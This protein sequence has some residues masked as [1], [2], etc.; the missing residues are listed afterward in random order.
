M[1]LLERGITCNDILVGDFR[2][3]KDIACTTGEEEFLLRLVF[4]LDGLVGGSP[5]GTGGI[6][7]AAVV[8][9]PYADADRILHQR[10][11]SGVAITSV[12]TALLVETGIDVK[13][14][15][16]CGP[17]SFYRGCQSA[18]APIIVEHIDI[19]NGSAGILLHEPGVAIGCQCAAAVGQTATVVDKCI[20]V[21]MEGPAF[22]FSNTVTL[23]KETLY[24]RLQRTLPCAFG[25]ETDAVDAVITEIFY[26]FLGILIFAATLRGELEKILSDIAFGIGYRS[27]PVDEEETAGTYTVLVGHIVETSGDT[28]PGIRPVAMDVDV[29]PHVEVVTVEVPTGQRSPLLG[30]FTD[31]S[32]PAEVLGILTCHEVLVGLL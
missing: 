11:P 32:P 22:F 26:K 9:T 21:H 29:L 5:F 13:G 10:L 24:L 23:G 27:P 25:V 14:V 20:P 2:T 18:F 1:P 6:E 30:E 12:T 15:T 4:A 3:V 17:C 28:P 16:A 31:R 8:G 19:G 7:L